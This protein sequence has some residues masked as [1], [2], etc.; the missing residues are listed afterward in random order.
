MDDSRAGTTGGKRP[1][2]GAAFKELLTL[3]FV[4]VLGTEMCYRKRRLGLRDAGG[5]RAHRGVA[6]CRD[7]KKV[8]VCKPRRGLR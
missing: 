1:A 7:S 5:A 2:S 4:H 8:T 6:K 3:R